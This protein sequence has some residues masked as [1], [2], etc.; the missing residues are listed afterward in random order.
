MI[1]S[2]DKLCTVDSFFSVFTLLTVLI[3]DLVFYNSINQLIEVIAHRPLDAFVS[4]CGRP[5]IPFNPVISEQG[6][7]TDKVAVAFAL[8]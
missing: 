4:F 2:I 7:C 8:E 6:S 5:E 3:L 1:L